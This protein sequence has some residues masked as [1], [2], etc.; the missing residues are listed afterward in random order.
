MKL[1]D[2][3]EFG[4]IKRLAKL[5]P[6]DNGQVL[7]GIGDDTSAWRPSPDRT[8][9]TTTDML[10]E[11]VHF[12][13]RWISFYDLGWKALA[14][15][16]SDIAAM[17]GEPKAALASLGLPKELEVSQ[18]EELYRGMTDLADEFE[19]RILGG[20][21]VRSPIGV[22]INVAVW[23]EVEESKILR[24]DTARVGDVIAVS[25]WLGDSSGGL[26][27]LETHRGQYFSPSAGLLIK[28]HLR[29]VPRI[30]IGRILG[31]CGLQCAIDISDGFLSEVDKIT[32]AS[33][34]RA[35]VYLERLPVSPELREVFGEEAP[36][37]AIT[38]G[39]DYE[40]LF[41][42]PAQV[43]REVQTRIKTETGL[44]T[45]IVG[46]VLDGGPAEGEN[47]VILLDRTGKEIEVGKHG[48]Q[49][50]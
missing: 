36:N 39:E 15:N 18:I 25:G 42:G 38:G 48:Y 45:T 12:R 35:I 37:F 34:K 17:G 29:P 33:G 20:D 23:G 9:L 7:L 19:V 28:A 26:S 10:I 16:L 47:R 46:E 22:I 44:E 40:L 4:L 6:G 49:A 50:F 11:D 8:I 3:G 2:L 27:L 21:T 31:E 13:L 32:E 41:S 24:R 1:S 14:V 43:V 5:V 30:K